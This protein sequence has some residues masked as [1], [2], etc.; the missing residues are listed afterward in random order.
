MKYAIMTLI[1]F[2]SCGGAKSIHEQN[3]ITQHERMIKHDKRSKTEMT[4]ARS[5]G[6]KGK[7]SKHGK[8]KRRKI[9]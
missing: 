8:R 9:I 2:C 7:K 6:S 5:K 3:M 1:M 4:K